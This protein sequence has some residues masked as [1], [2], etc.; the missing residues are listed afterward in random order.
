M[1]LSSRE[2]LKLSAIQTRLQGDSLIEK[3]RSYKEDVEWL[4]MMVNRLSHVNRMIA[5]D[6]IELV[7]LRRMKE[8]VIKFAN[9]VGFYHG[10]IA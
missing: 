5:E 7:D 3:A 2:E 6:K 1:L 10:P 9:E 8:S 4:V